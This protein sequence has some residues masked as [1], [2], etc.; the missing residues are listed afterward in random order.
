MHI[1]PSILTLLSNITKPKVQLGWG[2]MHLG[3]IIHCVVNMKNCIEKMSISIKDK[4]DNI[5]EN[6]APKGYSP[7]DPRKTYSLVSKAY[8][9]SGKVSKQHM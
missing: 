3:G 5:N 2:K 9:I 4:V 8:L 1:I 7:L 6:E